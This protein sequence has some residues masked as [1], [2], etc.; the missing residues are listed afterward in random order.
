MSIQ[1][2]CPNPDCG[3]VHKA[4]DKYAGL[5]CYCPDCRTVMEVP[6]GPA[7]PHVAEKPAA[8]NGM[9]RAASR[10]AVEAAAVEALVGLG[11]DPPAARKGAEADAVSL[12]V[13]VE[14]DA[15]AADAADDEAVHLQSSNRLGAEEEAAAAELDN[16]LATTPK[17]RPRPAADDGED[18]PV[19]PSVRERFKWL[20]AVT[21]AL[22]ALGL[23][24]GTAV[25]LL[26]GAELT[27][28]G[29]YAKA[30]GTKTT[31]GIP[32]ETKP[33]LIAIFCVLAGL[34]LLGLL[35]ALL[36]RRFGIITPLL[37]YVAAI[38]TAPMLLFLAIG[39]SAR[40][41][42]VRKFQQDIA[43]QRAQAGAAADTLGTAS[44][45]VGQDVV[46]SFACVAVAFVLLC[47]SLPLM[48]RAR[49]AK[50]VSAVVVG[51]GWLVEGGL[52]ALIFFVLAKRT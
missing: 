16:A 8:A 49:W 1:V 48:H 15:L 10:D 50:I 44:V 45:T 37:T 9:A 27:A 29:I 26:P 4:K 20:P 28:T 51:L 2:Q 22:G 6:A 40:Q 25:A 13:A 43:T 3:K 46:V 38:A 12:N 24:G 32:E 42:V 36:R 31:A 18:R 21:L 14:E 30:V 52:L 23:L 5:Q 47:L 17:G 33:Y 35:V 11:E 39:L 34:A 7:A 19:S 41:E